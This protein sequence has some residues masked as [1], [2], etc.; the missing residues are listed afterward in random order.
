M[1]K[2]SFRDQDDAGRRALLQP[3]PG[4][5]AHGGGAREP[6]KRQ[7]ADGLYSVGASELRS[8]GCDGWWRQACRA[9]DEGLPQQALSYRMVVFDDVE[10]GP[11][12][13]ARARTPG[14]HKCG[15][16]ALF[17]QGRP[18][19]GKRM[20]V[21]G[22]PLARHA[23]EWSPEG[24]VMDGQSQVSVGSHALAAATK[25]GAP[26]D[27]MTMP[28]RTAAIMVRETAMTRV[29]QGCRCRGDSM[30]GARASASAGLSRP[31]Q[32]EYLSGKWRAIRSRSGVAQ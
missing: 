6:L 25:G 16:R 7:K 19:S 28:R 8:E 10:G 22:R 24:R 20:R 23:E 32:L 11:G 1:G 17:F 30:P 27:Q 3:R 13:R 9:R 5:L 14:G 29:A 21:I 18:Q 15:Y 12:D 2:G 31:L 26:S 4:H